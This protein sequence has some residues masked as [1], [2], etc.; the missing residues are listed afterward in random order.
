MAACTWRPEFSDV[1]TPYIYADKVTVTELRFSDN[2]EKSYIL[3]LL[4][5][6]NFRHLGNWKCVDSPVAFCCV[7]DRR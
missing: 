1:T 5:R 3:V 7:A 4:N 6:S 2:S